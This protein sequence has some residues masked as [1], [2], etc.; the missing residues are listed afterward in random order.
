M[1]FLR[2]SILMMLFLSLFAS[3]IAPATK[4]TQSS[5]VASNVSYDPILKTP[6]WV[7]DAIFYQIF[8]DRFRDGNPNNNAFGDGMSGDILWKVWSIYA[9]NKTWGEMPESSWDWFGG[10]LQGV[11]EKAPYLADL[12]VTAIYF[13]P[14]MDSTSN[15]GYNV[16]DYKSVSRYFG[17]HQRLPNGSLVL[18]YNGSINVFRNMTVALDKYGIKVILDGVFNHCSAKNQW[19]DL[20]DDFATDGAYESQSSPWYNW[21]YF[22]EWPNNY[23]HWNGAWSMPEVE[24]VD[25]FKDY[26]YRANDSVIKFWNDLGVDGWRLDCG[27]DVS[28]EFWREFR[29]YYKQLNPEGFILGEYWSDAHN[30]L[31]GDQWDSVMNY[32]FRSA[33]LDWAKGGSVSTFARRLASIEYRYPAEA[34]YTCF[35]LLGSHDTERV[36]TLLGENKTKMKLAVIFQMT[37][38]GTPVIYYGDE[39]GM[40]GGRDPDCRRTYPWPDLGGTPDMDMFNH[41]KKLIAIRKSYPVLSVGSLETRLVDN[42]KRIYVLGRRYN[43]SAAVLIYN[44]GDASQTVTINVSDLVADGTPLTDVLNNK[45]YIVSDGNVTVQTSGMWANILVG[46]GRSSAASCASTGS[47]KDMFQLNEYVYVKGSGFP[48]YTNVRLYLTANRTWADGDP[49][50]DVRAS[51][52][53]VTMT[54]FSGSF[55]ASLGLAGN[56]SAAEWPAYYDVVVDANSNGVFDAKLDAVD[57]ITALPGVTII[58]EI[59]LMRDLAILFVACFLIVKITRKKA[60]KL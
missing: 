53:N 47:P 42:I 4:E 1:R 59:I 3:C 9:E 22:Y 49:I 60:Y 25:G 31:Q 51:G 37:Y 12:G 48:A 50:T 5:R 28:H 41:Y 39:V 57:D 46:S 17:A 20:D 35:N 27:Q 14:I 18:D 16:I 6:D 33:V 26:I 21:F 34:L 32:Q 19:F 54:D 11:Q 38:P 13:N 56:L 40:T 8:P 55:S 44:N 24:E 2:T 23:K 30:W 58:P 36:L 10:D 29:T 52:Y 7:K 43:Y 15:H 45:T